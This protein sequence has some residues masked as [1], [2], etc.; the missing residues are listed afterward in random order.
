[1]SATIFDKAENLWQTLAAVEMITKDGKP[2]DEK[3][4]Y[5]IKQVLRNNRPDP[6]KDKPNVTEA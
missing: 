1:M 5:T 4:L 3:T 2:L 6:S